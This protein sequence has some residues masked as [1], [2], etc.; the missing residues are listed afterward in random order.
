MSTETCLRRLF[1]FSKGGSSKHGCC[2]AFVV[3][4]YLCGVSCLDGIL[5]T[6]RWALI[7]CLKQVG[8]SIGGALPATKSC[9]KPVKPGE[10]EAGS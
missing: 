3:L 7:V 8:F 4:L 9:G 10:V 1:S 5:L 2:L 6:D